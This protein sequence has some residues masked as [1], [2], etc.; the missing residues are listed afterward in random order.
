MRKKL[1]F[2]SATVLFITL[3]SFAQYSKNSGPLFI[4][5][6]SQDLKYDLN[7]RYTRP[8]KREKLQEAG[9]IHELISGYPANWISNY[10]S[11]E[12]SATCNGKA[13]KAWSVN[14]TLSSAQKSILK[15]ADQ[16]ND[17]V[18]HVKYQ[19]KNPVTKLIENNEINVSLTVVPEVAAEYVGGDKQ[20]EKYVK[21]NILRKMSET[22]PR[23]FEQAEVK[24]TVDENGEISHVK[25][26]RASEDVKTDKVLLEEIRKMPKWKP[27]KDAK[28]IN[29][30]QEFQLSVYAKLPGGC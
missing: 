12:I 30:K 4:P 26:S 5:E 17:I 21:E 11:V 1:I 19:Y 28:G 16:A 27:A 29:V 23:R 2:T 6:L 18:I 14:E 9:F 10:V 13:V 3:S 7:G 20:L 8:I 15:A 25:L 24:F 22:I